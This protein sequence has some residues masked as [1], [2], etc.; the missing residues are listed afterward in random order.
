MGDDY[1]RKKAKLKKLR[2]KLLREQIAKE[3][4]LGERPLLIKKLERKLK[5]KKR[6]IPLWKEGICDWRKKLGIV[7]GSFE[8]GKRK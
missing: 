8:M 6:K 3:K 4:R 7:N 1:M 2:K 5:S